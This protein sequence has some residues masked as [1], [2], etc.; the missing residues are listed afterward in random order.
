MSRLF[1]EPNPCIAQCDAKILATTIK[2]GPAGLAWLIMAGLISHWCSAW[3]Q[4]YVHYTTV[5]HVQTLI[6]TWPI[7]H[8]ASND[9]MNRSLKIVWI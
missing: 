4:R 5:K 9:R 3:L 7:E 1:Q 2:Q 8:A 6:C